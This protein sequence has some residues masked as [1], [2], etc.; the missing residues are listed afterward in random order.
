MNFVPYWELH[1][2]ENY[3]LQKILLEVTLNIHVVLH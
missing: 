2:Q 3:F 1:G